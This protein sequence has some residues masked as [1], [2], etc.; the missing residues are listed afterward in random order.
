MQNSWLVARPDNLVAWQPKI[1]LQLTTN[2][3]QAKID[4]LSKELNESYK[5]L[6][7]ERQKVQTQPLVLQRQIRLQQKILQ[8]HIGQEKLQQLEQN[9]IE[10][11]VGLEPN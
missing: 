5:Q 3:L 11:L 2:N 4:S 8:T 10:L 6:E 7:L 9:A 1:D